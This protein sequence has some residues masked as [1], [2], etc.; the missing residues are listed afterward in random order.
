[1]WE[2]W[3][4]KTVIDGAFIFPVLCFH[5]C[6][7]SHIKILKKIWICFKVILL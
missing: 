5:H 7:M 6:M 3:Y 4:K 1:M 2:Q